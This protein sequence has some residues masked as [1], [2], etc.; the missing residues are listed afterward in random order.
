MVQEQENFKRFKVF[1]AL[2]LHVQVFLVVMLCSVVVEYQYLRGPCCFHLQGEDEGSKVLQNTGIL[3]QHYI[4]SP[5]HNP[6][7]INWKRMLSKY[8]GQNI[9]KSGKPVFQKYSHKYQPKGRQ[10][11]R[12][13]KF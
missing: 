2:K 12:R 6:Q 9:K 1:M 8:N 7:D 5:S 4:P 11:E 13:N 3:W 10:N